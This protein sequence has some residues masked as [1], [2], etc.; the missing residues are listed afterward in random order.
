MVYIKYRS[1][2]YTSHLYKWGVAIADQVDLYG[3]SVI[4][5]ILY[6]LYRHFKPSGQLYSFE[7]HM[8]AGNE[9]AMPAT[10]DHYITYIG[11]SKPQEQEDKKLIILLMFEAKKSLQKRIGKK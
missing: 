3:K 1:G 11:K 4:T 6:G 2:E 7:R 10:D 5:F 9:F 8:I